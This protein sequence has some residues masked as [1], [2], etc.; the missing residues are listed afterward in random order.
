MEDPQVVFPARLQQVVQ[1]GLVVAAGARP[2]AAVV[3]APDAAVGEHAPADAAVGGDA[4]GFQIA[5][6]LAVRRARFHTFA[7]V[8]RVQRQAEALAFLHDQ[9]LA[10]AFA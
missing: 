8:P 10:V 1:V 5:Q 4:G 7:G 2:G 3:E 6:D 9:R